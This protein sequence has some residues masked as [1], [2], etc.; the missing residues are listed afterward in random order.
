[1]A[2][3]R[4]A[5]QSVR[6]R[7]SALDVTTENRPLRIGC[8]SRVPHLLKYR[9]HR[10]GEPT[11]PLAVPSAVWSSLNR[12][13][14]SLFS[15]QSNP[16]F[17]FRLRLEYYPAEPSRSAAADQLLSWAFIPYSTSRIAGPPDAGLPARYVPPSGFGYPLGGFLPSIPCRFSFTPAALMGFTLRSVP[18][19][20][21]TQAITAQG[22]PPTVQ[23]A[24]APAAVA[25][26]RPCRPRFLGFDPSESPL[27]ASE[28]LVRLPLDAPLGFALLGS[29]IESLDQA[30]TRS[31][32]TRFTEP[33]TSHRPGRRPR[34]S[35]GLRPAPS[36]CRTEARSPDEATLLG[37]LHQSVPRYSGERPSGL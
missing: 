13:R 16:L 17:E 2:D 33:V 11:L 34:V 12:F 4:D 26:G 19:S 14:W 27:R 35:I 20:K 30:F 21:G 28:G 8:S 15:V 9:P 6:F 5:L 36:T 22:N 1:V 37:F 3:A 23:P 10:L 24:G 29:T 7:C 31:P 18:L 25:V 32:L